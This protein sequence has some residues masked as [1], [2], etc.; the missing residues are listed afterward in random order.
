MSATYPLRF[1]SARKTLP[2][3]PT[4]IA[5]YVLTFGGGMVSGDNID[6]D[7][8]VSPGCTLS[9]LS[10]AS[11]KVFKQRA[12]SIKQWGNVPI[13][14]QRDVRQTINGLVSSNSLLAILPEP[15]TCF[16]SASFTQTQHITLEANASLVLLDWFTCGRM[17]RGEE[18]EFDSCSSTNT[19][20]IE[21]YGTIVRDSWRLV[22]D[23]IL[24]DIPLL[25]HD[26]GGDTLMSGN[27][28]DD[29]EPITEDFAKL[30]SQPKP[31]SYAAR[32]MPY[33][34]LANVILIGPRTQQLVARVLS[35]F[36]TISISKKNPIQD[37]VIWS[38]SPLV[39][40]HGCILRA[41]ALDT[42]SMRAL[43]QQHNSSISRFAFNYR[44]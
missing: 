2:T 23:N 32:V 21:G 28:D 38:A 14:N 9:L 41:A 30:S 17:S 15:V 31:R 44:K 39:N 27:H 34:C 24:V 25:G 40:Q 36:A 42:Q 13:S 5:V 43:L 33:R 19:I 37:G 22:D 11:L 29:L 16:S 8:V 7:V 35:E 3:T 4:S 1:L 10:Q 20:D 6:M 26:D 18:W 12:V